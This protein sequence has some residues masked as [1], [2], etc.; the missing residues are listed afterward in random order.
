[1]IDNQFKELNV[2]K[3]MTKDGDQWFKPFVA[4]PSKFPKELETYFNSEDPHKEGGLEIE[5]KHTIR[6]SQLH[7]MEKKTEKFWNVI[8]QCA[9]KEG[10]VIII[11]A[12]DRKLYRLLPI[13][14][15]DLEK[16]NDN[17]TTS[18]GKRKTPEDAKK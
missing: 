7:T 3:L 16:T 5:D 6:V 11:N 12:N 4:L 9:N 13:T 1:M 18:G 17:Q 15:A 14:E 2:E 8:Q 10:G